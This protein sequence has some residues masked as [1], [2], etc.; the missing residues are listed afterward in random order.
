MCLLVVKIEER[1]EMG[2]EVGTERRDKLAGISPGHATLG[3]RGRQE[4]QAVL[5]LNCC[6][7]SHSCKHTHLISV[8]LERRLQALTKTATWG[9]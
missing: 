4:T 1:R 7:P 6:G 5:L 9:G 8:S 2:K 3:P